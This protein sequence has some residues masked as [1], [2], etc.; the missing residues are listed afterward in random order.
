MMA[1]VNIVT[2]EK[3]QVLTI[4]FTA[5]KTDETTGEVYVSVVKADGKIEKRKITP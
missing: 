2:Q 1:N 5:L 3:K 4:P